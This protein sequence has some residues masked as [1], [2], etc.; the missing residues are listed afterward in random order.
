[1][2]RLFN[3]GRYYERMLAGEFRP[4][5]IGE[6]PRRR[7]DRRIRGS[8]S[9]TVEYWDRF[10]MLIARVHEYRMPDGSLGASGRPDPKLLRHE[11]DVY[12]L[13]G[14]ERWDI[15]EW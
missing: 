4:K 6:I 12:V 3:T 9:Q 14:R 10:G 2:R 1:M 8:R 7:G 13:D 11:G 15:P 5:I